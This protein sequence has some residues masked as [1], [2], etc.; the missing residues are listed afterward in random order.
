[1]CATAGGKSTARKPPAD[2][3]GKRRASIAGSRNQRTRITS[4]APN[5][6][7]GCDSGGRLTLDIGAP[8][9]AGGGLRYKTPLWCKRLKKLRIYL[10]LRYK[11]RFSAKGLF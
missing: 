7:I 1:M 5:T 9:D 2:V 10:L 11:T 3:R 8:T 6:S 4:A